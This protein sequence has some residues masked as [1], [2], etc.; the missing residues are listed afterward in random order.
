M[1]MASQRKVWALAVQAGK[2]F[3]FTSCLPRVVLHME[4]ALMIR[5]RVRIR[6]SI[7]YSISISLVSALASALASQA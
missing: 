1:A 2:V 6:C 5:V 4:S 3:A 7:R